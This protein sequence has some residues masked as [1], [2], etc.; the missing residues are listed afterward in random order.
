MNTSMLSS[1]GFDT[2]TATPTIPLSCRDRA[3][4]RAVAVGRCVW[5]GQ[6]GMALRIDGLLCA[7][8]FAGTRLAAAGLITASATGLALTSAGRAAISSPD[9]CAPDRYSDDT[10]AGIGTGRKAAD[11]TSPSPSR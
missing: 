1:T 6:Q 5:V 10:K 7:D 2:P 9:H 3:L 11:D 8:Q 4:L